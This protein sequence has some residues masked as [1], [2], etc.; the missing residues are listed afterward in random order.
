MPL[1]L[2]DYGKPDPFGGIVGKLDNL[3]WPVNAY[4]VTLPKVSED[5]NVLNPFERVILKIIDAGGTREADGLARDTCIPVDLVQCVLLRLRDKGFIDEHNEIINQKRNNWEN[6]EENPPDFATTL[7]FRELATGKILPFFHL[8][9]D[10]AQLKKKEE[11]KHLRTI[12]YDDRHKKSP[13]SPR[14]VIS[15]LRA[16]MKR[17]LAFGAE[18]RMPAVQQITI[19]HETEL[20]YLDCPIAIQKSDGEFR[21]ADPFGNGFSLVLEN[22]FNRLLEQNNIL[23]DWLMNW[24][25]SLSNPRQD[26]QVTAH[27]EPYDNDANQGRYL[28]LVSNL[29]LSRNRR[30]CSI[31]QIHAALEWALFYACTQHPFDTA[32]NRLRLTN[33]SEHPNLLME[34]AKR[35]GLYPPQ[36]GFRLVRDGKLDDFLSG[37]AWMGTVLSIA[38]LMAENDASHPLHRIAAQH[39]D[40][41]IRI[42]DIEK[43]RNAQRHGQGKVQKNEIELPEEAFM[44]EIVTA[45]LPTIRFSGT[46]VAEVNKDD[47]ADSL[48]DARTSIQSEFGFKLFN[49]FGTNLQDRLICAECFW[50]PLPCNDIHDALYFTCDIYAALQMTFRQK[51]SRVLP[52]DIKD[53]KFSETAQ[54]IASQS[55]L[56]QLPECLCTVKPS[57]IRE[58]LQ[59]NDQTLGACVLA[60]LLVSDTDTLGSIADAQPSFI[61]DVADIIILS[62]HGNKPLPL[63]KTEIGKLRKSAYSTIKTLLEN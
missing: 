25:Q 51:L 13:L 63:P 46:P 28:N 30:H 43:K 17:S 29:R 61:S 15:A 4:R 36:Y 55:G 3:A 37:E 45:L 39:Q 1:K 50:L 32:I 58:T 27:K 60:F 38:L 57:A 21:I 10:N 2:L 5:S 11:K 34:A 18:T 22:A 56:E 19:A 8:L 41:I 7:M 12:P 9:D 62:K 48:L 16:M 6:K 52:P 24:K 26:K 49:R 44:R 47:V 33:Q 40:F 14:D 20:Y 59:G 35:V 23:S 54:K 31:E 42:F 53:S